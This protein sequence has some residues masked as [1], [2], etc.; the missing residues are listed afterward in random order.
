MSTKG[1][2]MSLKVALCQLA[3][4]HTTHDEDVDI[5][6]EVGAQG[7]SVF[8]RK[9]DVDHLG[10]QVARVDDA[11]LAVALAIP[12]LWTILQ[13]PSALLAGQ[14]ADPDERVERIARAVR[15]LSA[16][17]PDAFMLCTGPARDAGEAVARGQVIEAIRALGDEAARAGT[18]LAIEPMRASYRGVR[19]IV[20]S[21]A[22]TLD[23][24]DDAGRDEV[25]I[26]FDMWHL[27]DSPGLEQDLPRAIERITTVQV[28]DYRDPTRGRMDRVLAG[29]GVAGV[30]S[31]LAR[32]RALGFDG[33]YDLELFSDDGTFG[34]DYPD[35]LWR[36]PPVEFARRQVA[37]LHASL[38]AG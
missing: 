7:L 13:A 17:S 32:L 12:E 11:G 26:V 31:L 8:E 1:R 37:A 27:W 9:V 19:T 33:W 36:L 15:T 6:V 28:S 25:G 2:T 38:A 35:S 23:L 4:P 30:A 14:P 29:D 24:L 34:E 21:L 16:F 18:R 10:E 22:E 5:A 3:F 20:S